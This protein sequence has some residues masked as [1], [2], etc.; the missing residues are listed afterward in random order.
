[1]K[2]TAHE[3]PAFRGRMS[4]IQCSKDNAVDLGM[5]KRFVS[6]AGIKNVVM[7]ETGHSPFLTMPERSA[8]V[9]VQM[10]ESFV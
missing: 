5:Q 9:I 2:E 6:R 4:Y 7:F 1:M 3:Q 10:I 8:E